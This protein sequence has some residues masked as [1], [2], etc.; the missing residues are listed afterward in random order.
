MTYAMVQT[1][2][3][4][5]ATTLSCTLSMFPCT[6]TSTSLPGQGPSLRLSHSLLNFTAHLILLLDGTSCAY[7]PLSVDAR[8][9]YSMT[10]RV[11]LRKTVVC[12]RAIFSGANFEKC[13][14]AIIKFSVR[15]HA[16]VSG[17]ELLGRPSNSCDP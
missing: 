5:S 7:A 17:R 6:V 8:D 12:A 14:Y 16:P 11:R 2:T 9:K 13:P 10:E 1:L 3:R 4:R 15:A